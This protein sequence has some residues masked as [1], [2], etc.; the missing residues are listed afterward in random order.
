MG[1]EDFWRDIERVIRNEAAK[2]VVVISKNAF[3]ESGE[4]RD[5]IAKEIALSDVVK[6]TLADEYFLVPVR[7]DE[8][9]FGS[10]PIDFIRLNGIDCEKNW[11]IALQMLL[12]VFERDGVPKA[13]KMHPSIEAWRDVQQ[14]L[15][16]E[17]SNSPERLQSNWLEVLRIP[18]RLNFFEVKRSVRPN[19]IRSI[20]SSCELPCSDHGRLL[21]SF[22]EEIELQT[23]LGSAI[24]IAFRG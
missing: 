19:E 11:A 1:G 20:A 24:P 5:G 10:F 17:I 12:K 15:S 16:R 13:R 21:V 23:T 7:I 6:R 18:E 2:V 8:T 22:A 4:I 3:T 9:D 14:N